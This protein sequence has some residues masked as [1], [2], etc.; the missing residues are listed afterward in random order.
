MIEP[1]PTDEQLSAHFDGE[2][3]GAVAGHVTDCAV[4]TVRLQELASVAHLVAQPPEGP[5]PAVTER[6]VAVALRGARER[7]ASIPALGPRSGRRWNGGWTVA[8]AAAVIVALLAA[9]PLLA[10]GHTARTRTTGAALKGGGGAGAVSAAGPRSGGDL[11]DETSP[12]RLRERVQA[13]LLPEDQAATGPEAPQVASGSFDQSTI[14]CVDPARQVAGASEA[15]L[16]NASL[17][18][19]GTP[20]V[21][22]VFSARPS[23]RGTLTHQLLVLAQSDCAVLV[24]QRF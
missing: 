22:L 15:L 10:R 9:V 3:D 5:D 21:V 16:Y 4:C 6:A 18:W 1:H 24:S 17:R 13:Q 7:P 20:A 12:D 14:V 2:A 8:A 11:G 19:Q 23:S